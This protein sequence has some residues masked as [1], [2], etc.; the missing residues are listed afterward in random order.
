MNTRPHRRRPHGKP[1]D[2]LACSIRCLGAS[3]LAIGLAL[4]AMWGIAYLIDV[5]RA[6]GEGGAPQSLAAAAENAG[7]GF[8]LSQLVGFSFFNHTGEL[9]LAAI[10]GLMLIAAS[11]IAAAALAARLTPGSRRRKACVALLVPIPYALL[12]GLGALIVPLHFTARGLGEPVSVHPAVAEAFLLPFCWCLLFSSVGALVGLFGRRWLREG[13]HLLGSWAMPLR[14]SLSVLAFGLGASALVAFAGILVF[15]GD[16]VAGFASGGLGHSLET[17]GAALVAL[18][19][20]AAAVLLG[21]FGVSVDWSIDALAHSEGSLAAV[22]G[23]AALPLFGAAAVLVLGWLIA[24]R[25]GGDVKASLANALRAATLLTLGVWV[26]G[27]FV[28]V[29]AQAGGLLGFH[30]GPDP[31]SLLWHV[32]LWSF[33]G[34]FFGSSAHAIAGGTE[35]RRELADALSEALVPAPAG[36]AVPRWLDPARQTVTK[37]AGAG[38]AF[39]AVPVM[40]LAMGPSGPSTP[41]QPTDVSFAPLAKEA[42]RQL[43]GDSVSPS[44]V[45][46]TINPATRTVGTAIAQIPV[47]A[48]GAS[49]AT[50]PTQKARAVLAEYGDL[51]GLSPRPGELGRSYATTDK[52]GMTRVV[53]EQMAA[54]V[55]VFGSRVAVHF[56][57]DGKYVSFMSASVAPDISVEAP[58][59]KLDEDEAIERAKAALP[60]G[61][62]AQAPTLQVYAGSGPVVSGPNARLS[63]FVWL[64]D[65]SR[66]VSNVYVV[67]AVDGRVLKVLDKTTDA[68]NRLVYN[69]NNGTSLPGTLV[70]SEGGAATGN[71]DVDNAYTFSGDT[72]DFYSTT[73]GRDSYDNKGATLKSTAHYRVGYENAFWN[74]LQM[75]YGDGFASAQDVVGHE[76]T[77]AVT[78]YSAGLVYEWQSGALNEAFSDIM[79]ET[80]EWF[81]KGSPDWVMGAALPIGAIRSLKEPNEYEVLGRPSPKNLS[82]WYAGCEDN[83]GVHVNSTIV[84]HAYYLLASEIGVAAAA[85]IFYR[86]LTVYLGPNSTFEDARNSAIQA[87]IDLYGSGS[88]QQTKT[89]NAFNAVGLNGTAQPPQ[90]NC[91]G[92]FECSFAVAV[93]TAESSADLD[94]PSATAML[95]TLYKA[96]AELA[97]PSVAGQHFLPLYEEHMGRISELVA[98][99][100]ALAEMTVRGLA[101]ITPAL[102]ALIE[103]KGEEF[104]LTH[105]QMAKI[106]VALKRL[107]QDDRIFG[108]E[109]A[110]ELADL[111]GEELDW[112]GLPSYGGMDYASGFERLNTETE[113]HT[114][115]LE[116]GVI[117]DPNCTGDTYTND[118]AVNGLYVDTPNHRIPGEASEL[119]AGGVICGAEVEPNSAK[120]GCIGE[121]TLNTQVTVQL[122]P[123]DKVNSTKNLPAGSWVGESIGRVIACAGD[124]T[125]I[126][127]GQAGLLSLKSWSSSQCPTTAIACYEGRTQYEETI[128]RGYAWISESGGVLTLTTSPVN[129][130]AEGGY[131]AKVSFGQ[132]E[133]KLC[134]RAGEA[135]TES[136]GSAT[137][138]WIHQNGEPGEAGCAN[139]K[140]R[141]TATAK[142]AAG[143]SSL[144]AYACVR[145]D[146]EAKMQTIDAPNS[147]NAVSCVPS[148]TT[149]VASDSKGNAFYATNVSATSAATWTSWTGP[150][151]SPSWALS[152]PATTLCVIADGEV[153]GG[154]GNVYKATS[155]G[156]A[157][158]TSFLPANG[159]GS[160]SCPSASFC[161]TAQEGGGFIRYST[162]P[163]G[164]SWT[165]LAIGTG[166]MKGVSCLT[167]SFCAVVDGT[168]NVRVATT[169]ARVKEATGYASTNVNGAKALRAIAC[170]STTNCLAVDGGKEVLKLTIAQPAG[171]ATVSKVG[172]PSAGEL[173]TVTCNGSTCVTV[174]ASGGIF[175]STDGGATW[176]KRHDAG[177]K[178]T[179]VSCPSTT[180]CASVNV[181]GDIAMFKP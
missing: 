38:L 57:R 15:S 92:G 51:F 54:G 29:D 20:L 109:E 121:S 85:Q 120:T 10:P 162:K 126:I 70:R 172:V 169:E 165:T 105:A 61:D 91:S 181:A 131:E 124:K 142:N 79:G 108:G 82:E 89:T 8:Y 32:P 144:P 84:G 152:C 6:G 100:P 43:E 80:V 13:S 161:V 50:P 74:G 118:F 129:V 171:T 156:G 55:P 94:V 77:H 12:T 158:S 137:S 14:A 146:S 103:G 53:F 113:A 164:I 19:T 3:V 76:L 180:L 62:L 46:V 160:I 60:S 31:L 40:V 73:F 112:L 41:P 145:W 122:P 96:R 179:S 149:C 155:L 36:S 81:K 177:D 114:M 1:A 56:S 140:G 168:G 45:A 2:F 154:G 39:A 167:T 125:R 170:S 9:R 119:K 111:I 5:L 173:T 33:L 88:T 11:T 87:A 159:V 16:Q 78:E 68:R 25:S 117:T 101:E 58:E 128:G 138:P 17:L 174:D 48:A 133:V 44:S 98:Q 37:R 166:A 59:A 153:A 18:P 132:F 104:E 71:K 26:I 95:S 75:V 116:A 106:E 24:H 23:A 141:F 143:Q 67:D 30:L 21:S 176:L 47:S 90:P 99:D 136:C 35:S 63:W 134:D 110:G 178:L 127:Y 107:A 42:E 97:V 163:S 130:P 102:E 115:S 86:T 83:Y 28:R 65:D 72:Y 151:T 157:F 34:C 147:L 139:G 148:S 69:A 22:A 135:A 7:V 27:L 52:L 4:T 123:G 93:K 49:A 66:Q 175:T 64:L 150:G